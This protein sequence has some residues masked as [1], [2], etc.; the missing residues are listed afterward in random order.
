M[1]RAKLALSS[2]P[3]VAVLVLAYFSGW[4]GQ[5]AV[6]DPSHISI[7]ISVIGF[8]AVFAT[9]LFRVQPKTLEYVSNTVVTLGLIGTVF[10]LIFSLPSA[11]VTSADASSVVPMISALLVGMKIGLYATLTGC[12]FQLWVA[13]LQQVVESDDA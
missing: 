5:I 10:G 2:L 6:G 4:I 1:L 13:T 7:I 3:W 8:A 12:F 11:E 9:L